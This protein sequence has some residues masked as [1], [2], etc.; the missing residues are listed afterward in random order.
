MRCCSQVIENVWDWK[1]VLIRSFECEFSVTGSCEHVA[2]N[3]EQSFASPL[4]I[5]YGY[6]LFPLCHDR[7]V[8]EWQQ[9]AL[10]YFLPGYG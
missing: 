7:A 5:F 6:A 1:T 10:L 8:R 3:H 4:P 9:I 2:I